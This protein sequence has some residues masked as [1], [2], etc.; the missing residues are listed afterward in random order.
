M[1]E[2]ACVTV[3]GDGPMGLVL[4]SEFA[5]CQVSVRVDEKRVNRPLGS[6]RG[7]SFAAWERVSDRHPAE[8]K[9]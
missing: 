8:M 5:R 9:N 3:V 7:A 2:P 1:S 4:A 6:G